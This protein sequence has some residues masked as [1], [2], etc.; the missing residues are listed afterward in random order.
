MPPIPRTPFCKLK[1]IGQF[2]F[3]PRFSYNGVH[4]AV[5]CVVYAKHCVGHCSQGVNVVE[6]GDTQAT[7]Y[8]ARQKKKVLWLKYTQNAVVAEWKE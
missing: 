1:A 3:P 6:E 2:H 4:S 7:N 8:I 5:C